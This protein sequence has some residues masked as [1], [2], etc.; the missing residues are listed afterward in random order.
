MSP[1]TI[2]CVLKSAIT[3]IVDL[4]TLQPLLPLYASDKEDGIRCIIHP[5]HGPITQQFKPIPNDFIRQTLAEYCPPYLDGELIIRGR[6]F[7]QN[8]SSIMSKTGHPDWN[9]LVFD[10]FYNRYDGFCE[11]YD[12]AKQKITKLNEEYPSPEPAIT[13]ISQTFCSTV[14]ALQQAEEDAVARGKEGIMLRIPGGY[15]K[16]GRSTFNEGFLLKVKRFLDDEACVIGMEEQMEN[17]NP[18]S[19]AHDNTSRR[20][21]HMLFLKPTAM[22][23]KLLAVWQ[24]KQIKIGS[25]FTQRQRA[26]WWNNPD[27]IVG[28]TITFKYQPHGTL[29]LPRAPIFKGIRYD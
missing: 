29:D 16:E 4:T 22:M 21:T 26:E 5:V 19:L 10:S 20:T 8:Q 7:Y 15:Y 23:G 14:A 9:F 6:T 12:W 11:R 2:D 13:I 28:K 25:G 1:L 27:A 17:R 3:G 24:G 18:S